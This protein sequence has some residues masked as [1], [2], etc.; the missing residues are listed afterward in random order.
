MRLS[1][2][3]ALSLGVRT[4]LALALA[5]TLSGLLFFLRLLS[6]GLL[7]RQSGGRLDRS[8]SSWRPNR[9]P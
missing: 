2:T 3:R 1:S 7:R 9:V 8:S 4:A 6:L 5:L